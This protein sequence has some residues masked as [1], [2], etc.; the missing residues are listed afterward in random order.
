MPHHEYVTSLLYK[1]KTPLG[2]SLALSAS[3]GIINSIFV[4]GWILDIKWLIDPF[5]SE[6][7]TKLI[8]AISFVCVS[9]IIL[10]L[11]YDNNARPP[12]LTLIHIAVT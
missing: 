4:L 9:I 2:F 7:P 1:K 6:S 12:L 5:T 10:S 11:S 3:L 8:A